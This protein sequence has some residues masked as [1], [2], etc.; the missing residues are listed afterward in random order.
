MEY[1]SREFLNQLVAEHKLVSAA[2]G[3]ILHQQYNTFSRNHGIPVVDAAV[4]NLKVKKLELEAKIDAL[5]EYLNGL[6]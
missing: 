1:L 4:M 6:G 3:Q 2:I 5:S